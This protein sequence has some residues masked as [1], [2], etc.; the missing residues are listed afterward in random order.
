MLHEDQQ[1]APALHFAP[2]P[3][4]VVTRAEQAL[5]EITY[6]GQSLLAQK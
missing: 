4:D 2:L 6:E 1:A 3:K 5:T